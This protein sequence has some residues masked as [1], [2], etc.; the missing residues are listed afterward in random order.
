MEKHKRIM[1]VDDD[2]TMLEVLKRRLEAMGCLID[3]ASSGNEALYVLET[4]WVDL[5]ILSVVLHGDMYG[6]HLFKEI[7][8]RKRLSRVPVVIYSDK[9]GMKGTFKKMGA[10]MFVEKPCSMDHFLRKIKRFI[11]KN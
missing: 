5:I 10:E 6:Y 7:K 8:K 1:I 2:V 4:R 11:R 3:C 9:V